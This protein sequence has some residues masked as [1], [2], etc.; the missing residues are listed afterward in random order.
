MSEAY[1]LSPLNNALR[2]NPPFDKLY[3][4]MIIKYYRI[5]ATIL[6]LAMQNTFFFYHIIREWVFSSSP[7]NKK[8]LQ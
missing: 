7:L 8:N 5:N 6:F 1:V 4:K 2:F 3:A